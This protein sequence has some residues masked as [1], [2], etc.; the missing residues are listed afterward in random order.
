M[1]LYNTGLGVES[2][3][4]GKCCEHYTKYPYGSDGIRQR[5]GVRKIWNDF[6]GRRQPT[7]HGRW[8]RCR[9][10][11]HDFVVHD[12]LLHVSR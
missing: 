12:K 11:A 3:R 1:G 5:V 4:S 2:D 8:D 7:D 10:Q 6:W 9:C